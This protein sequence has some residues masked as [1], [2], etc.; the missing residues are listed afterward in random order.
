MPIIIWLPKEIAGKNNFI[1]DLLMIIQKVIS[2][3]SS[4]L[5][6]KDKQSIFFFGGGKQEYYKNTEIISRLFRFLEILLKS[7]KKEWASFSDYGEKK[8]PSSL[9]SFHAPSLSTLPQF[10]KQ[11]IL[12]PNPKTYFPIIAVASRRKDCCISLNLLQLIVQ[13]MKGIYFCPFSKN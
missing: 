11:I 2:F 12:I 10:V 8:I 3:W 6:V 7:L 5:I 1:S 4:S 13:F 9:Q